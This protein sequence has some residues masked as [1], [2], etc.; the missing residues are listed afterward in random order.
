MRHYR[1]LLRGQGVFFAARSSAD[2]ITSMAGLDLRPAQVDGGIRRGSDVVKAIALGADAVLLGRSTLYVA[3]EI[4]AKK[5]LE[6]IRSEMVRT[7]QLCGVS[8]VE[9]IRPE[10]LCH[11]T[12]RV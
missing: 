9:A 12:C 5:A 10:I 7:M 2:C 8:D 6:I 11:S 1:V 4:G 3:G